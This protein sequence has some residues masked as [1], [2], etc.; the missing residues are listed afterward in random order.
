M[1]AGRH[2]PDPV[3][4]SVL[5]TCPEGAQAAEAA[6]GAVVEGVGVI[7]IAIAIALVA[8]HRPSRRG[9]GVARVVRRVVRQGVRLALLLPV[10]TREMGRMRPCRR[11]V[12]PKHACPG[13]VARHRVIRIA[14]HVA[15]G[16][17]DPVV[18]EVAASV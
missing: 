7:G 14:S 13:A 2:G 16:V 10:L 6:V 3:E 12:R 17:V 11:P 18:A 15:A 4:V 9:E 8:P 1:R 5:P